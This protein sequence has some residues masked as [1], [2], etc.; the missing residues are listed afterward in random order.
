MEHLRQQIAV[1]RRKS[2]HLY[3]A[4]AD[5]GTGAGAGIAMSCSGGGRARTAGST[6]AVMAARG[7]ARLDGLRRGGTGG[8]ESKEVDDRVPGDSGFGGLTGKHV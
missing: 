4:A 3:D 2:R 1:L 5:A 8:L 6:Q 7:E